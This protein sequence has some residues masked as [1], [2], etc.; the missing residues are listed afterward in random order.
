MQGNKE[1]DRIIKEKLLEKYGY[2]EFKA[3]WDELAE[4]LDL[5]MQKV[6]YHIFKLETQGFLRVIERSV[7][8]GGFTSPNVIQILNDGE[9]TKTVE[10]EE[11]VTDIKKYIGALEKKAQRTEALENEVRRLTKALEDSDASNKRLYQEMLQ[12]RNQIFERR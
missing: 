11:I 7:R 3:R 12:L 5:D 2:S 1:R 6:R 10:P 9:Q 8:S 4:F